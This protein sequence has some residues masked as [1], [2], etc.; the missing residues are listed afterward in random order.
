MKSHRQFTGLLLD[1]CGLEVR[2]T[3]CTG[4]QANVHNLTGERIVVI[5][6]ITSTGAQLDKENAM[7]HRTHIVVTIFTST[8]GPVTVLV[9]VITAI[10]LFN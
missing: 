7:E 6:V 5:S 9:T 1:Y 4:I 3:T 2:S 10:H 8:T